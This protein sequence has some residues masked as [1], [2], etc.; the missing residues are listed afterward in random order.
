MFDKRIMKKFLSVLLCCC[1]LLSMNVQ[2]FAEGESVCEHSYAEEITTA[3]TCTAEGVKTFTCGSCGDSYTEAIAVTSHSY[4]EEITTAAAC[5]TEG[6]KTFTCSVCGDSYTEAITAPG[7]SYD[8][9][10][11]TVCGEAQPAP[12]TKLEDCAAQTHEADCLKKLADDE[13]AAKAAADAALV[14]EVNSLI[15]ALPESVTAE[16]YDDV[17]AQ[18]EV[19]MAKQ[20]EMGELWNQL[21]QEKLNAVINATY[22]C[23]LPSIAETDVASIG[24]QGYATLD[25]AVTAA[26]DGQTVTLLKD[27]ELGTASFEINKPITLDL[28]G[29]TLTTNGTYGGLRLNGNCSLTNGTLHHKGTV[30]AI[31]AWNVTSISNLVITVDFKAANK[32]IGG[33]VIQENAAGIGSISNVTI[34]GEGLTNGIETFNC[35]NAS[36]PVIGSMDNVTINAKGAGMLIS[37]PC[38]TATNCNISGGV[39]GIE[40]WTKGTYNSGITLSGGSVSGGTQAVYLHD[41]FSSDPSIENK[42]DLT[43]NESGTSFSGGKG[44]TMEVVRAENCVVTTQNSALTG[45]L[46][47]DCAAK[48]GDTYYF[49]LDKAASEVSDGDTLTLL[50]DSDKDIELPVGV[51]LDK[52][53]YEADNVTVAEPAAKIGERG[54]VS[55]QAA[56]NAA[57]NGD[58][59]V[60]NQDITE[61]VLVTQKEGV[62]LTIDGAGKKFTGVMTVFGDGRHGGAETLTIQSVN[63]Y[64]AKDAD[65]C[66]VSPD[67]TVYSKYSYSHNVTVSGCNF[68]GNPATPKKAAA[69]RQNDGGDK[70]WTISNC[71]VDENMH[72]LLQVNNVEGKLTVSGCT[73][74]SKNG[75]NLNSCTNV[76][77]TG[78]NF[79]VTGYA[80]RAGVS[81]GGNLGTAKT[82]NLSNNTLS[83]AKDAADGDAVI[84]FRASA[85]DTQ[86]NM[87]KNVVTGTLHISG[88]TDATDI[89]A[90]ANH[91]GEGNDAPIVPT[92]GTEVPVA[93]YYED[94][95]LT[96]LV[97]GDGAVAQLEVGG[98]TSY[99][100]TLA[101][102]VSAV[103]SGAA[104]IKLLDN[105]TIS[106]TVTIA[107]GKN[108][109]LDLG[110][111]TI[112]VGYQTAYPT[113]HIYA[114]DNKGSLTITGNGTIKAGG[115]YNYGSLS[116]D[117]D[118]V[119]INAID[120]DGGACVWAYEGS[121]TSISGGNFTAKGIGGCINTEGSLEITGGTFTHTGAT[122]EGFAYAIIFNGS[123]AEISNATIEASH[124][125]VAVENGILTIKSGEYTVTSANGGHALYV[126]DAEAVVDGGTFTPFSAGSSY[127]MLTAH[128]DAKLTVNA[129]TVNGGTVGDSVLNEGGSIELKGGTFN[130]AVSA[131]PDT[132]LVVSGG[133]Y[134]VE[135]AAAYIIANY[136]AQKGSDNMYAIV[137]DPGK[138]E[139]K[140]GDK[141]YLTIEEAIEDAEAGDTVTVL[142][143]IEEDI[144]VGKSITL[145]FA[146]GV[147]SEA[148]ITVA[149]GK[150]LTMSLEDL[151]D[152]VTV[153]GKVAVGDNTLSLSDF[154]ELSGDDENLSVAPA[155]ASTGCSVVINGQS[156]KLSGSEAMTV[157]PD[158]TALIPA[159]STVKFS[160]G[161][162]IELDNDAELDEDGM[163]LV[164]PEKIAG[165][166]YGR[167]VITD[168][169]GEKNA[170]LVA[171]D[172]NNNPYELFVQVNASGNLEVGCVEE[173][174]EDILLD[175][176]A[177]GE[178]YLEI[179]YK[180][181]YFYKNSS[182][183]LQF[184]CNGFY[185]ALESVYVSSADGKYEKEIGSK[186]ADI[187]R[188]STVVKLKNSYLKNLKLGKYTLTLNY[189]DG[190]SVSVKFTVGSTPATGDNGIGSYVMLMSF[191][192]IALV[193]L[194]YLLSKKRRA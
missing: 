10:A 136:I 105:T 169:D 26:T 59:I 152:G 76:E 90:D 138:A 147:G 156:V 42:G 172:K 171:L 44:L 30:T 154:A 117:S 111:K 66:I 106:E 60:F 27:V 188:G 4:A 82:Y 85:V 142:K 39:S 166:G 131:W 168:K 103:D 3:A 193:S 93:S 57:K 112:D 2:A 160:E 55:L 183:T 161:S 189:A 130:D 109:T 31:K 113:R 162:S 99:Y 46:A 54:F 146:D 177:D 11:C 94:A 181:N 64:A 185:D 9:G 80:V 164:A 134:A 79:D 17:M 137:L 153:K 126:N 186:E 187:Y 110:G 25:A 190:E 122:A 159:G 158:G 18:L 132:R 69:V 87:E 61:N 5:T 128:E 104:L 67:R 45:E 12:C 83:G 13:A 53:I 178:D 88:N 65:S 120:N 75:V 118:N 22:A 114:L 51:I 7:H 33:I 74:K 149:S 174:A 115:I 73:V 36:Q 89:D 24:E 68:Y 92:G 50:A 37:A 140:I 163:L 194:V 148:K 141:N 175:E 192:G 155:N 135:P 38:G 176:G 43:L 81:T 52:G 62:N 144:T 121:S 48:N 102:A 35:G 56:I 84:M 19:I 23:V 6:V 116:I 21:N 28:G 20:S 124:G 167:I 145:D 123:E 78:C 157:E 129:G 184:T 165:A 86:L 143:D 72:S 8:A 47:A 98:V 133:K 1:M 71:T 191:S 97:V 100:G 95:E 179:T 96:K 125:A 63:F 40:L 49:S 16:N 58:T 32:V 173:N 77:I 107:E 170:I 91:W 151:A 182:G 127:G 29:K 101:E 180:K 150:T 41:E 119:T 34:G 108:I 70:N 15:E 139:A 14:A